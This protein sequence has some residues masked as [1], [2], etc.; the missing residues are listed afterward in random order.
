MSSML[1]TFDSSTSYSSCKEARK[2]KDNYDTEAGSCDD[3]ILLLFKSH[4]SIFLGLWPIWSYVVVYS[5]DG[6]K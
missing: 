4:I 5:C 1:L 6:N 2:C 3:I